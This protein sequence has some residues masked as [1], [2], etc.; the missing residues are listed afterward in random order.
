MDKYYKKTWG[1]RLF[2]IF[3]IIFMCLLCFVVIYPFYN[4]LVLSLNEGRDAAAGGIYFWPRKFTFDNYKIIFE[5]SGLLKSSVNSI[6][7]VLIGTVTTLFC[8][9]LLS[10]VVTQRAFSGR[11]FLR[12]VF[13]F[14]MY[15]SGGMIPTYLL[16]NQLHLT[17][18][19]LVYIIPGL[20]NAYYML[21][22]C[23]YI[24]DLPEAIVE[25][26]RIDG[27]REIGIYCRIIMPVSIPIF[28]AIAV[29]V[30]VGHWNSWFDVMIYNPNGNWDTL[31][32]SLRRILLE[33]EAF[34]QIQSAAQQQQA[35]ANLTVNTV[36]AAT[37]MV[38][39]IPIVCVYPFFQKYFI[40]GITLGSVKQ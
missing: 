40:G 18:T 3:N 4:Q 39:T 26:A 15:F 21:L 17:N 29:Y 10:Y 37:A 38:V 7:R 31:Q 2:D 36:R 28:A 35:Y 27:A 22:M 16:M 8:T 5:D 6:L 30:A 9:G 11:K 14:T 1:T 24:Q 23:S 33:A 13:L 19:F 34:K 20:F 25:A 12:R 32:A